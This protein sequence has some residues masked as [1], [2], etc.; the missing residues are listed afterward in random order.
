MP[1]GASPP[2]V[3]WSRLDYWSQ[4]ATAWTSQ[5]YGGSLSR[6]QAPH[7][8]VCHG[9]REV[10]VEMLSRPRRMAVFIR[11]VFRPCSTS[12]TPPFSRT[13]GS[14]KAGRS[15]RAHLCDHHSVRGRIAV[16]LP[17][18]SRVRRPAFQHLRQHAPLKAPTV[19]R[20]RKSLQA[21]CSSMHAMFVPRRRRL[22][23]S[24]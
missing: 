13:S 6:W 24:L 11:V 21:A 22:L 20:S 2:M 7:G 23:D 16:D 3:P 8:P 5:T 15:L 4:A 12:S 17:S 18:A 10:E 14:T 1:N 9:S 19:P